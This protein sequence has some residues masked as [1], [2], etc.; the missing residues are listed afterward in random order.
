MFNSL[1]EPF[2]CFVRI[3]GLS[4]LF[5]ITTAKRKLG[6]DLL[7][8][9]V[10][11][12][13]QLFGKLQQFL[14]MCNSLPEQFVCF[15]RIFGLFTLF[16]ITTAKPR[17][18]INLLPN[19][20]LFIF[21]LFGKLQLF[22]MMFNSLPEQFVCFIRIFGLSGLFQITT[23][24]QILNPNLLS[25]LSAFIRN[26]VPSLMQLFNRFSVFILIKELGSCTNQTIHIHHL[27]LYQTN[28][29]KNNQAEI[30]HDNN[31]LIRYRCRH[32]RAGG[33]PGCGIEETFLPD[34]FPCG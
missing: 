30:V 21:Q 23:A 27:S 10:P 14:I 31:Q 25:N 29:L 11:S 18:G 13:F 6:I 7:P 3:L 20:V 15:V 8:N 22:L 16:Q 34:K 24:K 5:Q 2:V 19:L 33:N 9:L 12:I 1:P 4:G 17:L 28:L 26:P 32:S